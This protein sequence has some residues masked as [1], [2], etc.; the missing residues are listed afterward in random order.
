VDWCRSFRD[1]TDDLHAFARRIENGQYDLVVHYLQ[2]TGHQTA[3]VLKPAAERGGV[4]WVDTRTAGRQG[5]V[6][7]VSDCGRG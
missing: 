6:A 3:E 1:E 2:K 5:V 4:A 7:A